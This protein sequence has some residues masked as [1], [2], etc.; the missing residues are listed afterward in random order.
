[1]LDGRPS[2]DRFNKD[3]VLV[4]VDRSNSDTNDMAKPPTKRP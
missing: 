3:A 4:A 2:F 1:M